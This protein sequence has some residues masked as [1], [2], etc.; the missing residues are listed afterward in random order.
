[1]RRKLKKKYRQ[2]RVKE[3]MQRETCLIKRGD[4]KHMNRAQT[5]NAGAQK[6]I[7][8]TKYNYIT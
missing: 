3:I 1:M 8:I 6:G 2:W 7:N 4:Y 5:T